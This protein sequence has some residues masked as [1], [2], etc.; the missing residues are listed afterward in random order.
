MKRWV[1]SRP[2]T[3]PP[4]SPKKHSRAALGQFLDQDLLGTLVGRGTKSAGPS[5]RSGDSPAR[6]N[7]GSGGGR[8]RAAA[9]ITFRQ[10][11][12]RP[13]VFRA[14]NVRAVLGGDHNPL[15]ASMK[16]GTWIFMPVFQH[17]AFVGRRGS[18]APHHRIGFAD[19][20]AD[21]HRQFDAMGGL[22]K[23]HQGLIPS[24]RK[25]D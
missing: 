22:I 16:G 11:I 12:N 4:S 15:A 21:L 9:I 23:L 24:C 17:R 13:S 8:L 14:A 18:A 2:S 7:R 10:A 3:A 19:G 1:L 5:S 20:D 6:R 25:R